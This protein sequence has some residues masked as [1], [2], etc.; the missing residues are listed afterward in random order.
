MTAPIP[1][2]SSSAMAFVKGKKP[3]ALGDP[4]AEF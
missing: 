4:V 2:G 3:K 1:K